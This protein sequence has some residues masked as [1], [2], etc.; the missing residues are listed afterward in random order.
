MLLAVTPPAKNA[1]TT[2]TT[3]IG[4]A[5]HGGSRAN[6]KD[7]ANNNNH[8]CD[9]AVHEASTTTTTTAGRGPFQSARI[10]TSTPSST[11]NNT[12]TPSSSFIPRVEYDWLLDPP[13]LEIRVQQEEDCRQSQILMDELELGADRSFHQLDRWILQWEQQYMLGA[14]TTTGNTTIDDTTGMPTLLANAAEATNHTTITHTPVF[15]ILNHDTA[16]AMTVTTTT[17]NAITNLST[18]ESLEWAR[19]EF[20]TV[21]REDSDKESVGDASK[22]KEKTIVEEEG[23]GARIDKGR[24][25]EEGD[26]DDTDDDFGDFQS[27]PSHLD[28]CNLNIERNTFNVGSVDDAPNPLSSQNGSDMKELQD[29]HSL[30]STIQPDEIVD[31]SCSS[32]IATSTPCATITEVESQPTMEVVPPPFEVIDLP[33]LTS[34]D[35]NYHQSSN[36]LTAVFERSFRPALVPLSLSLPWNDLSTP[37]ARFVRRRQDRYRKEQAHVL[38]LEPQ[39]NIDESFSSSSMQPSLASLQDTL[40]AYY[41]TSKKDDTVRL[42]KT[43]PWPDSDDQTEEWDSYM[44]EELCRLD[45]SL[46]VINRQVLEDIQPH[47][48]HVQL[49]NSLYQDLEQNVQRGLWYHQR[50]MQSIRDA[51]GRNGRGL[52]GQ[53][54]ILRSAFNRDIFRQLHSV[55]DQ[56]HNVDRQMNDIEHRI[57]CLDGSWE[58]YEAILEL[59]KQLQY[60]LEETDLARLTGLN[61][62]RSRLDRIPR[63]VWQ[64]LDR[65]CQNCIVSHAWNPPVWDKYADVYRIA[66]HWNTKHSLRDSFVGQWVQSIRMALEYE[67][68]LSLV[69]ALLETPSDDYAN[70]LDQLATEIE[71]DWGI[72]PSFVC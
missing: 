72:W 47:V 51:W 37:E 64:R 56:I 23:G 54:D 3:T 39:T 53:L 69:K 50:A 1:P 7:V 6:E 55:L 8:H 21:S 48:E 32:E 40:P 62:Y 66:Q 71:M 17:T 59:W 18:S 36:N 19:L 12:A 46:D 49:A 38:G 68:E 10:I 57:K 45:A 60:A 26:D 43:L 52:S 13:P 20:E 14:T 11:Y 28:Q 31:S 58:N 35:N 30:S 61:T 5:N 27:A 44:T 70:E 4:T 67:I 2:V 15:G 34:I 25:E 65:L 16:M 24:D 42:L 22:K 63:Q 29:T 41:F 9:A 33:T